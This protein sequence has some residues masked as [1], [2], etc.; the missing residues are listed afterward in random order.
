M[1]LR[2]GP[3]GLVE[4]GV[5]PGWVKG[6]C[7]GSQLC[8]IGARDG[9]Q[10]PPWLLV[11][12]TGSGRLEGSLRR[13]RA[14]LEDESRRRC[15]CLRILSPQILLRALGPKRL[16]SAS[17]SADRRQRLANGANGRLSGGIAFDL[18]EPLRRYLCSKRRR[19]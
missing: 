7:G 19:R 11:N 4:P 3:G 18:F 15:I 2:E 14:S 12:S 17:G 16:A 9:T 5:K 1:F 8:N 6:Q 10:R 13:T